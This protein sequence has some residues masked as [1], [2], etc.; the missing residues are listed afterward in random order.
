M[1]RKLPWSDAHH[2]YDCESSHDSS[3]S[4]GEIE[5]PV[6]SPHPS[7]SDAMLEDVGAFGDAHNLNSHKVTTGAAVDKSA[8]EIS[9]EGMLLKRAEMYQEYMKGIPIPVR[10]GSVILFSSWTGLGKS[11]KQLY[12]QPLHYLTNVLL[13]Q[14]DQQRIGSENE[15]VAL[16]F[17]IHPVKAEATI[18]LI[19]ELHRI[20]PSPHQLA[21]FWQSDP[22]YYAHIDSIPQSDD[23]D[24]QLPALD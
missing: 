7:T 13:K 11:L 20:S 21:K 8:E 9:P 4:G 10:R 17:I 6:P 1:K 12:G 18:W 22:M 23:G 15:H 16:D 14:W 19:E 3:S 24:V 2:D 5:D